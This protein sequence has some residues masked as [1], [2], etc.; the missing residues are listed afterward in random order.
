MI[1]LYH[2][3]LPKIAVLCRRVAPPV[4]MIPKIAVKQEIKRTFAGLQKL[5]RMLGDGCKS[6]FAGLLKAHLISDSWKYAL[7]MAE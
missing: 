4:N 7:G 6:D 3:S 1:E 2:R 5:V